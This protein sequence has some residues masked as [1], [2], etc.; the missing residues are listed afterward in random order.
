MSRDD[1]SRSDHV[2]GNR[3]AT[4][5][6]RSSNF[7][8]ARECEHAYARAS[9]LIREALHTEGVIF[10]NSNNAM[11]NIGR[12]TKSDSESDHDR[13]RVRSTSDE[14]H[15]TAS[16]TDTSDFGSSPGQTCKINGFSTRLRSTLATPQSSTQNFALSESHLARLVK[17]YP[18][19][20]IFNFGE[21]GH[22][23][24]SSADEGTTT[25]SSEDHGKGVRKTTKRVSRLH[26][27][28][29]RLGKAL[30]GARTIAFYPL[31]D[32]SIHTGP[33]RE[34]CRLMVN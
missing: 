18:N 22:L 26:G 16:D 8:L 27:D 12:S 5:G 6:S 33:C 30:I 28:A 11:G 19:G 9:N 31:W 10:L 4:S 32:V 15:P 29:R 2:R 17:H 23:Y 24:S 13:M 1:A 7:D 20:K 3:T 14:R 25:G 34:T 21:S